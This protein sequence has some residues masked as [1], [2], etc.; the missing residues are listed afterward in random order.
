MKERQKE[1]ISSLLDNELE[2]DEAVELI[3]EL[4]NDAGLNAQIDRY[5]LIR[6]AT[7]FNE[8]IAIDNDVFLKNIQSA[9]H[10]HQ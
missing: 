10:Q 3:A 4:K 1:Q 9:L 2:A 8:D 5:A 6:G 7:A